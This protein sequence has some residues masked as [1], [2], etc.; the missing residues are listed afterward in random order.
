MS[1]AAGDHASGL[2]IAHD[3]LR[4]DLQSSGRLDGGRG[5]RDGAGVEPGWHQPLDKR[6]LRCPLER[7]TH[8]IR[9]PAGEFA[10]PLDRDAGRSC[11]LE[12]VGHHVDGSGDR[13]HRNVLARRGAASLLQ[14][15]DDLAVTVGRFDELPLGL[16]PGD[17]GAR[18][19]DHTSREA[20]AMPD[21][22]S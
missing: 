22:V 13:F 16:G 19:A 9:V 6:G 8:E 21:A 11:A 7:L 18:R 4:E 2:Q 3:A 15:R 1:S 5:L 12:R 17:I 14:R 20:D 10:Q